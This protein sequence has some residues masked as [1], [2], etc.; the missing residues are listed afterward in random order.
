M[1]LDH[2]SAVVGRHLL[3]R[4]SRSSRTGAPA[5]PKRRC[6]AGRQTTRRPPIRNARRSWRSP[7]GWRRS[8]R[9][10]GPARSRSS[11]CMNL[12]HSLQL[13]TEVAGALVFAGL[14][15]S[16][17]AYLLAERITRPALGYVLDSRASERRGSLGIGPRIILTWALLSG[18]PLI[19]IAL[20]PIGRVPDDPQDLVAPIVFVVVIALVTGLIAMKLA[21]QAIARPVQDAARRDGPGAR[22]RHRDVEV[23]VD[24]ASEI[25]RLQA[26]FNAMVDGLRERERLR[27]LF[28][29]HV[30]D[31]V[32]RVALE[33]GRHARRRAAHGR[34]AVRRR[35]RLD[36]AG[37]ARV[38]R[39]RRRAAQ[40]VLRR[41]RRRRRRARRL[42]QQVRGRRRRVRLRR[43]GRARR[44]RGGRARGGARAARAARSRS[45]ASTPRSAS[46]AATPWPATSGRRS[47]TST[48]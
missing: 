21:A 15:T 33:R 42:R 46:R 13:A 20:I 18:V 32:A 4:S 24:D 9:R 16:A 6:C 31:D 23:K 28:G 11:S 30:G 38:A 12:D 14:S 47:A 41:G 7:S 43:P 45:A 29:R 39:A 5:A 25:G 35:D 1:G 2:A 44:L 17:L 48:R 34:D 40:R 26:G 36:R 10:T 19:A 37:G 3:R 27:E 8:P 22:G